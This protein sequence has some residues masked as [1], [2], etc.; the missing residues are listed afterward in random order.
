MKNKL[1]NIKEAVSIVKDGDT[2]MVGGFLQCGHPQNLV[3]ALVET[4]VKNL[5]LI[6]TDTGNMETANYDLLK[7]N[8]VKK[9]MASYIGGNPEAGRFLFTGAGEVELFPQGTLAEKIRAGGAGLGGILT[10]VG[11]GTIVEQG[12]QKITVNGREYLLELPLR[13]NVTLL[14]ADKADKAG[15]LCITGSARN[16]NVVMA[17]AAD[18]VVAEVGEIVETGEIDPNHVTIPGI[19]IDV[20]VKV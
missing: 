11:I 18:Y 2:I 7:G 8:K 14:K 1:K 10:P 3:K 15:N 12:K 16:F 13:A 5:T 9:I 20:L 19:F 4:D 17:T 6:S